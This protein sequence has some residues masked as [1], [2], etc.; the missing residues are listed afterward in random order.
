VGR[1]EV[2]AGVSFYTYAPD[3]D[4]AWLTLS[5][6]WTPSTDFYKAGKSTPERIMGQVR[7]GEDIARLE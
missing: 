5:V 2:A 3:V 1:V 4:D 7:P 6:L